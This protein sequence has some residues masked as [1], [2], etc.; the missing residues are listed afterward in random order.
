MR[1]LSRCTRNDGRY[2]ML[3]AI[4][5]DGRYIGVAATA[6]VDRRVAAAVLYR[7]QAGEEKIL[8]AYEADLGHWLRPLLGT[9][10][11]RPTRQG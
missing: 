1:W 3:V 11:E 6:T 4:R 8:A 10:K 2:N 5:L 9:K 7:S